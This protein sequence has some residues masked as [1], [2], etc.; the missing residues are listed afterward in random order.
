MTR[1]QKIAFQVIFYLYLA[2][3]LFLCFGHF[4]SVPSV[5]L[6]LWGIP[7]DK[8]VHFVMFFPFPILAFLA[9]DQYS[10]TVSAA[11]I[12]VLVTLALGVLLAIGTEWGQA[13]LTTHRS[14]DPKDLVSDCLALGLSS[15][16]VL[17]WDI[18]KLKRK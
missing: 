13:H 2:A 15:G 11:L 14:G 1:G 4:E 5:K 7:M 12:F 6:S 17:I 9:F 18:C 8:I 16:L 3:V 10:K